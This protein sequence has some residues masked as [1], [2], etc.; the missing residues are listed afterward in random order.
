MEV[1]I[2]GSS[3]FIGS[4]LKNTLKY[5]YSSKFKIIDFDKKEFLD[6]KL[7]DDKV[8]KS[9]IIIHLAAINRHEDE[10]FLLKTNINLSKKIIES[11]EKVNF[12]GKLIFASSTQ[13]SLNNNY[14]NSK[15]TSRNLFVE[16]SKKNNFNFTALII[17]N[18]FGPFGRPNYNSFIPTFCEK[19]IKDKEVEIIKNNQIKL[20]YIDNLVE[21]IVRLIKNKTSN[22]CE[23]IKEDIITTVEE[24]RDKLIF[25]RSCYINKSSIPSFYTDFDLNLFNTFRSYIEHDK[26][27]PI[28]HI[29]NID[30][31]GAF[32]EIIRSYSKGQYSFSTTKPNITRGN[33]FHTRKI[34][35]FS[36][37]SGQAIVSLRKIG[38]DNIHEFK[39]N[40][41]TPSYIDIPIWY[42]HNI[43]NIG[44]DDLITLFWIN[45]P[46]DQ[47][48][49]DTYIENV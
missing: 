37:I 41:E 25:Y 39:L 47:E 20:I 16:S 38:T 30:E 9:S 32:V 34:E 36:V 35:R 45:E 6:Q 1:L 15:K 12:K 28:T 26:F 29:K 44:S 3:G 21:I 4:H 10:D 22:N 13:E 7:L 19:I 31:R 43:K 11:I 24:V 2:T 46:Y 17:P 14:G 8:K 23:N 48:N 27:F 33:H 49:P 5:K 40:G 18:V 42:T